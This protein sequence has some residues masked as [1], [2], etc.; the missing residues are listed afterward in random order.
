MSN[1]RLQT[2][3]ALYLSYVVVIVIL[4]FISIRSSR[5][6][7]SPLGYT[8]LFIVIVAAVLFGYGLFRFFF[9]RE[10]CKQDSHPTIG[11]TFYGLIRVHQLELS[12]LLVIIN[13]VVFLYFCWY[14][15]DYPQ[16]YES[17]APAIVALFFAFVSTLVTT[18]GMYYSY[19]AEQ[20]ASAADRSSRQLLN[21][22]GQFLE[23][24]AGFIGRIN[25]KITTNTDDAYRD[26]IYRDLICR[27][28]GAETHKY[29]VKCMFLTPF[30]A[31]AGIRE[32]DQDMYVCY[33]EFKKNLEAI[34]RNPNCHVKIL[35]LKS[36][37]TQDP[38]GEW[39]AQIQFVERVK[40]FLGENEKTVKDL[41]DEDKRVIL[42]KVRE[43]LGKKGNTSLQMRTGD[44]VESLSTIADSYKKNFS[45]CNLEICH[46]DYIPFQMFLVMEVKQ[47]VKAH[48]YEDGKFVVLT[49]VGDKTYSNVIND[50]LR[51][52]NDTVRNGGIDELLNNLHAAYYSDDPRV[53]R[54]LNTHFEHYW[55]PPPT[56]SQRHNHYPNTKMA[57]SWDK[58]KLDG[59]L[60]KDWTMV[61]GGAS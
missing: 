43:Y 60:P 50:M 9:D 23:G 16:D 42:A 52:T 29:V 1:R 6:Q 21:D 8:E 27:A 47:D 56:G 55:D 20:K 53:C 17:I 46:G 49:Y 2:N 35:T 31:H 19:H 5:G 14:R 24:F 39:Y 32:D 13:I 15:L 48:K 36:E 18:I 33:D 41:T 45:S 3:R 28:R 7:N 38:L 22:R 11:G 57:K 51:D 40:I 54:I 61:D 30:L 59:F 25:R 34:I 37:E 4:I 10:R 44:I 12:L 26:S 58:M